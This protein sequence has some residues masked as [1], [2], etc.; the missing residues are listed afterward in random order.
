MKKILLSFQIQNLMQI[1][2]IP[3]FNTKM[4]AQPSRNEKENMHEIG[5]G[6]GD[7]D[8]DDDD[9]S[10]LIQDA[11]EHNMAQLSQEDDYAMPSDEENQTSVA[12]L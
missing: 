10:F 4:P 12:P 9:C 2:M 1:L 8:G 11:I 7:F 3:I 6:G 5:N